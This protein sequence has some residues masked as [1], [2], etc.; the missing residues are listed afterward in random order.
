MGDPRF[1]VEIPWALR[2]IVVFN[3]AK[4]CCC[5]HYYISIIILSFLPPVP[6]VQFSVLSALCI[7]PA[8]FFKTRFQHPNEVI[9]S[10]TTSNPSKELSYLSWLSLNQTKQFSCTSFPKLCLHAY[11]TFA[12][13][14]LDRQRPFEVCELEKPDW[15]RQMRSVF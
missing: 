5:L 11:S 2:S 7:P 6:S 10:L 13:R 15:V 1:G 12:R 3:R 4:R 9:P 8:S 14:K